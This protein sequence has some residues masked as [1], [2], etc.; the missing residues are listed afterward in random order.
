[1]N[2][3]KRITARI[4]KLFCFFDT[5]TRLLFTIFGFWILEKSF[6]RNFE[7]SGLYFSTRFEPLKILICSLSMPYH[8]VLLFQF[9]ISV[10]QKI[11]SNLSLANFLEIPN[12]LKMF[13]VSVVFPIYYIVL[14]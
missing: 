6:F 14:I 4:K 5:I 13:S 2:E 8:F 11:S 10:K 1:M 3:L 7:P 9:K 12:F